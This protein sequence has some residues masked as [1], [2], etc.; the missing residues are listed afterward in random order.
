MTLHRASLTT[1]VFASSLMALAPF[2]YGGC[3]VTTTGGASDAS[4]SPDV[5]A[6]DSGAT[7][8]RGEC[9]EYTPAKLNTSKSGQFASA[10]DVVKV[11]LPPTDVGGGL[12]TITMKATSQPFEVGVWLLEGDKA[13][14][15]RTEADVAA[16]GTASFTARL[17]GG[18]AYEL[19]LT[20][21][22]FRADKPN[23][24]GV[25]A[26][27][28]ALVDCYEGNDSRAAAKRIPTDRAITAYLHAGIGP[29]DSRLV[30]PSGDD[31]YTFDLTEA[32]KVSLSIA[33]PGES[34]AYVQLRDAKDEVVR[35]D[36]PNFGVEMP[37]TET[38]E[39]FTTCTTSLGPGR[40]WIK[41]GLANSEEASAGPNVAVPTS[42]RTPYTVTVVT[43]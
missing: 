11:A 3:T 35:C 26:K 36:D 17:A 43:K 15:Q 34:T 28:E 16:D 30:G 22:D 41:A 32:K 27:Y 38:K 1:L 14:E 37:G 40:Y 20:P 4:T 10:E 31:W 12:L 29:N 5:T 18:K 25:E 19:R 23:G 13:S 6:A 8:D 33:I 9:T 2:A 39:S 21:L 24:Y 42:W 7:T